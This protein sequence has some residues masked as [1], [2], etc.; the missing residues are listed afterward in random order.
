[1]NIGKGRW[2]SKYICDKCKKEIPFIHQKGFVGINHYSR[3]TYR[4][5]V[6]K[7]SFDLCSSC[8]KKFR[9]WLN[10]KEL[11]TTQDIVSSFP[12]YENEE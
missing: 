11:P 1:M 8:E 12:I 10:E 2:S 3:S 4:D 7:K 9:K 5:Q 6:Y